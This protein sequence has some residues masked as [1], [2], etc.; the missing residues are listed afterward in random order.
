VGVSRRRSL[1]AKLFASIGVVGAAA[2]CAG[3]ATYADPVAARGAVVIRSSRPELVTLGR[4]LQPASTI[5]PGDRVSRTLTLTARGRG[6]R[7]LELN[8]SA[9]Q[10][11]LLTRRA[12]GLRLTISRCTKRWRRAR[13]GYACRGK[14]RLIF[15]PVPVL[16]R[17]RLSRTSVKRGQK[18]FLLLT[19]AL[20]AEAGNAVQNQTSTLVYRFTGR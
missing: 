16:G 11:S 20:P 15:K 14:A 8:V 2:S 6:F 4:V 18:L 10:A 7:R 9:K 3:L 5:A 19:L 12:E 1:T 17:R 13:L